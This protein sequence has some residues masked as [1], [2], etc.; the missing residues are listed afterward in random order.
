M[1]RLFFVLLFVLFAVPAFAQS[2]PLPVTHR[3]DLTA[4]GVDVNGFGSAFSTPVVWTVS[5]QTVAKI[6]M[7]DGKVTLDPLKPGTVTVTATAGELTTNV[8]FNIIG[9]PVKLQIGVGEPYP[10]PGV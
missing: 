4:V 8:T 1:K 5:D 3:I 6:I 9:P 10:K 2:I 7:F